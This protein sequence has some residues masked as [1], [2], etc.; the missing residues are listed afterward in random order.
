[1]PA[2][3]D[4]KPQVTKTKTTITQTGKPKAEDKPTITE[5]GHKAAMTAKDA[6]IAELEEIIIQTGFGH[7]LDP[8]P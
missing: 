2:K 6:R 4:T 5:S 7:K 3:K 1:M 8:G